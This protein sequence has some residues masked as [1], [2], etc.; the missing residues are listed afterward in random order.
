MVIC[1]GMRKFQGIPVDADWDA[2]PLP[3]EEKDIKP[4]FRP[5]TEE[6]YAFMCKRCG[7]IWG[8]HH[9]RAHERGCI[10]FQRRA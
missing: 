5:D 6:I 10:Y 7:S 4:I 3:F 8:I 2:M 9:A 1:I